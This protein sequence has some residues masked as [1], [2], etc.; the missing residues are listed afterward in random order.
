MNKAKLV[1][2]IMAT[3]NRAEYIAE[4]LRSIQNQTYENFEC[5]II[6]DG[7]NDNTFEVIDGME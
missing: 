3:Y 2:I 7:G 1:S 6:D 5:L 4:S